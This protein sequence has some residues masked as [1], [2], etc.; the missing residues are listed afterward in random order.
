LAQLDGGFV[1]SREGTF[2][3]AC[4]YLDAVAAL[5]T[6]RNFDSLPIEKASNQIAT[7]NRATDTGEPARYLDSSWR[8]DPIC[9][10][11]ID[12]DLFMTPIY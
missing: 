1:V 9:V 2:L 8:V 11:T 12:T 5:C 3:S 7:T 10:T 6:G 4:R